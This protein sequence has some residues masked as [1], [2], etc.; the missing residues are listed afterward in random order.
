MTITRTFALLTIF[1]LFSTGCSKTPEECHQAKLLVVEV[2]PDI[3]ALMSAANR[4]DRARFEKTKARIEAQLTKL[5]GHK[6]SDDSHKASLLTGEL[7]EFTKL[8]GEALVAYEAV[9]DAVEKHAALGGEG[10][11]PND[12]TILSD[13]QQ[14]AFN[15]NL[16]VSRSGWRDMQCGN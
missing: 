3:T 8:T 6:F 5:K 14:S 4:G 11:A 7:E 1:T 12:R 13:E 10:T 9:L 2:D 16:K 15:V